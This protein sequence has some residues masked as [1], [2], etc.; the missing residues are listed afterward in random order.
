MIDEH[1]WLPLVKK[2]GGRASWKVPYF[3]LDLLNK[4][5]GAMKSG[6]F[7]GDAIKTTYRSDTIIPSFVGAKLLVHRGNSYVP[8]TIREDM[9]GSK[10]GSYVKTTKPFTFRATNATKKANK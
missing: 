1:C 2:M 6:M 3:H 7:V 10:I 8:L 9:I 4:I 5:K